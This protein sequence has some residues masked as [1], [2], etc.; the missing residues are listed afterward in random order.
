MYYF[1]VIFSTEQDRY[2]H[3]NTARYQGW[4]MFSKVEYMP[5]HTL[6]DNTCIRYSYQ[7][8]LV[9]ICA[10]NVQNCLYTRMNEWP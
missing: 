10:C 7:E 9:G 2:I 4:N 3:K 1:T 6:V 8:H 5:V